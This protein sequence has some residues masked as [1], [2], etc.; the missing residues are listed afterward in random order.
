MKVVFGIG[1]RKKK[2][3]G[4]LE[5]LHFPGGQIDKSEGKGNKK[6]QNLILT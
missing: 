2:K 6:R 5:L 4:T 3:V 1:C